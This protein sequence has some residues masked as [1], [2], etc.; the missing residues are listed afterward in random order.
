MAL[1]G[2][3]VENEWLGLKTGIMDQMI[4]AAGEEGH[5]LLIDCRDLTWKPAPIPQGAVAVVMDT[6]TRRGLVNSAYNERRQQ[7]EAAA[8]HFNVRALRDVSVDEFKAH[9]TELDTV[10]RRR[11]RHVVTENA[12]TLAAFD[13]MT[14]GDAR[15]LGAL[16]DASHNSLEYDFEVST[17]ALNIIVAFARRHPACYGARMT[18]AGFGG[19]AVALVRDDAAQDFTAW[20]SAQYI[21]GT[22]NNPTLYVCHAAAGASIESLTPAR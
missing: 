6:G 15:V 8:K 3:K 20:V 21:A 12:R 9:E 14:G 17:A 2:Q 13:A 11:A 16:M 10:T 22:G 1:L 18:G 4:S 7:C 19:C 5:A